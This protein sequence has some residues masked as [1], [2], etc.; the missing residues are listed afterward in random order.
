MSLAARCGLPTADVR[1]VAKA[2]LRAN[3]GTPSFGGG[4]FRSRSRADKE[5]EISGS[6]FIDN[7]ADADFAA[8]LAE[9]DDS[10]D[11]GEAA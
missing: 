5:R 2:K 8:L 4:L 11:S 3:P 6:D 1:E 9:Y 10:D 7:Y